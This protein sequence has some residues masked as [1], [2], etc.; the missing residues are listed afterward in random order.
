MLFYVMKLLQC[1]TAI[2]NIVDTYT[3]NYIYH[4]TSDDGCCCTYLLFVSPR[5]LQT[6]FNQGSDWAW[7]DEAHGVDNAFA[8]PCRTQKSVFLRLGACS[9]SY[10]GLQQ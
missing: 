9:R 5:H 6:C 3:A 2:V 1:Q 4:H 7:G 10:D 8:L